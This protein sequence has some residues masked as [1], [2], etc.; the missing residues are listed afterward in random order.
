MNFT[1]LATTSRI[2]H[3]GKKQ[4]S[5]TTKTDTMKVVE[6]N[7]KTRNMTSFDIVESGTQAMS[8]FFGGTDKPTLSF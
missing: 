4:V 1:G 6:E 8:L 2:F 3:I 5:K 7:S